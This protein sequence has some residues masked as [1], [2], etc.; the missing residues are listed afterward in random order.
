MA[1]SYSS[2]MYSVLKYVRSALRFIRLPFY[3]M[4]SERQRLQVFKRRWV[5]LRFGFVIRLLGWQSVVLRLNHRC[6]PHYYLSGDGCLHHEWHSLRQHYHGA[7]PPS[8]VPRS[9]LPRGHIHRT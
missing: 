5:G 2:G 8:L 9:Q 1:S 7:H 3:T 4:R 6:P